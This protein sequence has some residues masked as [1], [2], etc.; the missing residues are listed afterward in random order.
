MSEF[1]LNSNQNFHL[2]IQ[3]SNRRLELLTRDSN[4]ATSTPSHGEDLE[5]LEQST[6]SFF[7]LYSQHTLR[8]A[9]F[10]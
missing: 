4:G 7:E 8:I 3:V 1:Y 9:I 2:K 6:Y 5:R 10:S